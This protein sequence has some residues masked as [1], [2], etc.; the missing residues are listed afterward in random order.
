MTPTLI[1]GITNGG[2]KRGAL[3]KTAW[4]RREFTALMFPPI[5]AC[6]VKN[7]YAAYW[8]AWYYAS[9]VSNSILGS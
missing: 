1:Q 5:C 2:V 4:A 6:A 8:T 3:R 7:L 9:L